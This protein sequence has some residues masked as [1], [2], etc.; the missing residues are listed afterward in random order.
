MRG[1]RTL[2][3]AAPDSGSQDYFAWQAE[4]ATKPP[5]SETKRPVY[6]TRPPVYA[7]TGAKRDTGGIEVEEQSWTDSVVLT[8]RRL[9]GRTP[10]R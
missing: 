9:F 1:E 4:R 8:A 3:R 2:K 6:A 10:E 5:Q 7:S